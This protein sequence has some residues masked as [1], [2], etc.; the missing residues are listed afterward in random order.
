MRWAWNGGVLR[1][2][3]RASPQQACCIFS[4]AARDATR[5]GAHTAMYPCVFFGRPPSTT[6]PGAAG[7]GCPTRRERDITAA[8]PASVPAFKRHSLYPPPRTPGRQVG[9]SRP[10]A[11][12][13]RVSVSR[14][15]ERCAA[16]A[17][18]GHVAQQKG[19]DV[20]VQPHVPRVGR[21]GGPRPRARLRAR[22]CVDRAANDDLTTGGGTSESR[23]RSCTASARR[24]PPLW[25][26]ACRACPRTR[27][28]LH[29]ARLR[30][31]TTPQPAAPPPMLC[32]ATPTPLRRRSRAPVAAQARRARSVCTVPTPA[33][34]CGGG[35]RGGCRQ[36]EW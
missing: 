21:L 32:P 34:G 29:R 31:R 13:Q 12:A 3:D 36:E 25:R 26:R 33:G 14:G 2:V 24:T 19:G 35:G 28:R 27:A 20:R 16:R 10:D 18:A 4:A 23:R 5:A 15:V 7:V 8:T 17:V 11:V 6:G 30:S 9:S 22:G 1:W